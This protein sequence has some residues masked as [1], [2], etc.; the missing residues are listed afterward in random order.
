M[1]RDSTV[2]DGDD[3]HDAIDLHLTIRVRQLHTPYQLPAAMLRI[4]IF[5]DLYLRC[6]IA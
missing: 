5:N 4:P 6:S 3:S 1:F 2:F